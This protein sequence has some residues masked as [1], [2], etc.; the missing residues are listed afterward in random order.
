M[1][2]WDQCLS[3]ETT[4]FIMKSLLLFTVIKSQVRNYM[5]HTH[6]RYY[7]NNKAPYYQRVICKYTTWKSNRNLKEETFRSFV[8][9]RNQ[10][11]TFSV[12]CSLALICVLTLVTGLMELTDAG[13]FLFLALRWFSRRFRVF[14]WLLAGLLCAAAAAGWLQVQILHHLLVLIFRRVED[15]CRWDGRR[16][17]CWRG[18]LN[19]LWVWRIC[20]AAV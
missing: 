19:R 16:F 10:K 20:R 7:M 6:T 13:L 3:T 1:W 5:W 2:R 9:G 8:S 4:P 11:K 18:R 12:R 14:V 17:F 15:V